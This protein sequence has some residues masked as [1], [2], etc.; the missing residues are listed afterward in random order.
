MDLQGIRH[1]HDVIVPDVFQQGVAVEHLVFVAGQEFQELVLFFAETDGSA[2]A[3]DGM[4]FGMERE[5]GEAE[6][7]AGGCSHKK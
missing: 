5:A 2:V 3:H 4:F 7:G 6:P 1:G